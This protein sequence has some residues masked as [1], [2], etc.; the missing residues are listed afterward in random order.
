[1]F[2]ETKNEFQFFTCKLSKHYKYIDIGIA[3]LHFES[4]ARH[5]KLPGEWD[6]GERS[7]SMKL[8]MS[9]EYHFSWKM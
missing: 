7:F 3:M 6:I 1:V 8:P 9:M 2:D 5:F 4:A